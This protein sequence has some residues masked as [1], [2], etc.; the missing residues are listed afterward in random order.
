MAQLKLRGIQWPE[1]GQW[2]ERM[3]GWGG[4]V[5]GDGARILLDLSRCL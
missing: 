3:R 4:R 1:V 2:N 5:F